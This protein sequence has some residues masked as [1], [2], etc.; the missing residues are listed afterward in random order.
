MIRSRLSLLAGK[1]LCR[2]RRACR[3]PR[4]MILLEVVLAMV[5]FFGGA[6][7]ILAGLSSSLSGVQRVQFEAQAVDL[8]VTLISEVQMG[9]VQIVSDGPS[10]YEDPDLADWTWQIA[11][12]PYE[13]EQLD[14]ELPEFQQVEVTIRHRLGYATSLTILMSD[15]PPISETEPEAGSGATILD[16]GGGGL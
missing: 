16:G 10:A 12:Q 4:A 6:L 13:E 3:R 7:V 11:V 5:L 8:A 9:T 1:P 2:Q 14:L 15:E